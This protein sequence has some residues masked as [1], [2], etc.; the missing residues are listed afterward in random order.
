MYY[1]IE[2]M[3]ES[4][5]AAVQ[6]IEQESLGMS[7]SASTYRRELHPSSHSRY[8]VARASAAPPPPQHSPP[9]QPTRSAGW[10]AALFGGLRQPPP[11]APPPPAQMLVG[12]GG[13]M[14]TL[15]EAHIT[16]IAVSPR[17]RQ[18]GIGELLLNSLI[19]RS[20]EMGGTRMTLEVRESN[21]VAQHLYLKYGFAPVGRRVRYYTDNGEDALIMW[22]E[23]LNSPE[24]QAHLREVRQQ[25]YARLRAQVAHPP[26]N[27]EQSASSDY[28]LL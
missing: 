10:L 5:I 24:Y 13:I 8:V 7:W 6:V 15:D 9:A 12:F 11:A 26:P 23:A 18:R 20:L 2:P 27:P 28:G 19:D 16:I 17:H 21:L 3:T 22:T 4:D 14:V 25:L 1:F